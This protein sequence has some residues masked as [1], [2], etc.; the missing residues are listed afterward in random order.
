[1][2]KLALHPR[3]RFANEALP[4][5]RGARS[6]NEQ[7]DALGKLRRAKVI[8]RGVLTGSGSAAGSPGQASGRRLVPGHLVG[9][10]Q[11]GARPSMRWSAG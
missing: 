6:I 11:V 1:M 10:R 3:A 9:S 2:D 7:S 8:E 4:P 5:R